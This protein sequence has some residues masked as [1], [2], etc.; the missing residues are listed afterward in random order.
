MDPANAVHARVTFTNG[1]D[2]RALAFDADHD[3]VWAATSGGLDRYDVKSHART[4]FGVESGLDSLDVRSIHVVPLALGRRD[5]R[6][7]MR[8]KSR[9]R[10]WPIHVRFA[11]STGTEHTERR[12]PLRVPVVA[13]IAT[14]DGTFIATRGAGVWLAPAAPREIRTPRRSR[15]QRRELRSKDCILQASRMGGNLRRR[16]RHDGRDRRAR[17]PARTHAHGQRSR[18]SDGTLFIAANEGFFLHARRVDLRARRRDRTRRDRH[19]QISR[20]R[21]RDDHL[22]RVAPSRRSSRDRRS[23]L[24]STRRHAIDSRNRDV[25]TPNGGAVAWMASEDRGVIRFDPS[26]N[27]PRFVSFDK[28]GGA[29]T[30][31]VVA[32]A[33]DDHGGVFAATLRDGVFHVGEGGAF[34]SITGVPNAWTLD[35]SFASGKLCVGTQSGAACWSDWTKSPSSVFVGLP[36]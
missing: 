14:D 34:A 35:A 19:R 6:S 24:F 25:H 16:A 21:L 1:D 36:D 7:P 9:I 22:H 32:L 10:T 26:A 20:S 30:S 5:C 8:S 23:Q 29:P 17:C 4:H 13:R 28:L 27:T 2:V 11:A 15:D 33:G 18:A 3:A 12:D 31:W